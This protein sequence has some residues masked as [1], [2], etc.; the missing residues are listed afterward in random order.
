M[1]PSRPAEAAQPNSTSP[2]Q[3]RLFAVPNALFAAAPGLSSASR[4]VVLQLIVHG[5]VQYTCKA[6]A[7]LAALCSLALLNCPLPVS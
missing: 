7:L 4:R 1:E 6:S 5:S 3:Q 2:I